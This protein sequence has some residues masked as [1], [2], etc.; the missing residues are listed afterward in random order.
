MYQRAG[1][2][3]KVLRSLA[4]RVFIIG[5]ILYKYRMG[6]GKEEACGVGLELKVG[7]QK[8]FVW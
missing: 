8:K 1:Q 7:I 5:E 3:E 2:N 4:A 6:E